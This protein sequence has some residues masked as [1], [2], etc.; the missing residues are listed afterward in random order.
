MPTSAGKNLG[1]FVDGSP[2]VVKKDWKQSSLRAISH[3]HKLF[4]RTVHA[5]CANSPRERVFT[6]TRAI[7][8]R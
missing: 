2:G 7:R 5:V 6:L 8:I 3:W 1:T 4:A